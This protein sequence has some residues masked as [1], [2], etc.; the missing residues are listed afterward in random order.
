[1]SKQRRPTFA[2]SSYKYALEEINDITLGG[3]PY[4][5]QVQ[6]VDQKSWCVSHTLR[7]DSRGEVE[8]YYCYYV[9]MRHSQG[10]H[11]LLSVLILAITTFLWEH[12]TT[13]HKVVIR[14]PCCRMDEN[15]E[16]P[17]NFTYDVNNQ[18]CVL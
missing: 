1:M 16:F 9:C 14:L 7:R 17:S 15:A 18:V 11:V 10:Y 6:K 5:I 8:E 4:V 2:V 12:T 3:F 13:R